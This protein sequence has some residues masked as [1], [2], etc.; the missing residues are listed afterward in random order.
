MPIGV[1][2]IQSPSEPDTPT[3]PTY[4]N[5][6]DTVGWKDG[7][8]LSNGNESVDTNACTSGYIPITTIPSTIYLKN[9]TMPDESSHGN[10]VGYY[11][12]DKSFHAQMAITSS[13]SDARPVFG[14][15]GNL[16]QFYVDVNDVAY[17]RI[18]A[19]NIDETSI[20]TVNEPID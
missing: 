20:I 12:A 16:K 11:K 1:E 17:I 14:E 19:W 5:V 18:N 13:Y 6:L 2:D 3:T 4:T 15:D 9:V 7:V 8:Y 10:R